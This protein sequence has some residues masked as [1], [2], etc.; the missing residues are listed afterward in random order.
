LDDRNA[1]LGQLLDIAN[2]YTIIIAQN[3]PVDDRSRLKGYFP[4]LDNY[5]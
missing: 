3:I 1:L 2:A 5:L 4:I